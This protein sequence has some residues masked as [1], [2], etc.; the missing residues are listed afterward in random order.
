[1]NQEIKDLI[2]GYDQ[3]E[4]IV[5]IEPLDGQVIIFKEMENGE[6]VQEIRETDYWFLT[7]NL[8]DPKQMELSGNQWYKYM[9]TFPTLEEKEKAR[10]KVIKSGYF[11]DNIYHMY[12]KKE[13]TL[14]RNG[15]TY[16][17]GMK[18]PS[19]I[20]ILSTDIETDGLKQS[21]SSEIY[22]ITN[23]FRRQGVTVQQLFCLADFDDQKSM[24]DA[25]CDWVREI[26]PS[27]II[28]HNF[29]MY[30]LPYLDHVAK[31]NGTSLKLGRDGSEIRFN[32]Y[33]SKKRKD[34]SQD[35]MYKKAYIFGREIVDSLFMSIDYD[36]QRSFES[37]ALKQII[38]DLGLEKKGRS[39]VDAS[40]IKKYFY[41]RENDPVMWSKVE[42]YAI[43][44]TEDPITLFDLMIPAKFFFT[45]SVSKS[46]QEMNTS[47]TG[48]Q[49]NNILVRGYLQN[50]DSV[51]KTSQ[52][53]R[54]VQGGV[55][56]AIPG[57]YKNLYKID[58]KSCYPSQILR[59]QLYDKIKDPK[60]YFYKMVKFFAEQRFELKKQYKATKDEYYKNR[61]G[62]AKIVINSAYGLTI[63]T[64]L[65]YNAIEIGEKITA[66]SRKIID[67]ALIW[68]SG[69]GKDYWMNKFK[70]A[71]GENEEEI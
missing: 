48:S 41:N 9:A 37:Y 7:H 65:N 54:H 11:K 44:D 23:T 26:D 10:M 49:I 52:I 50:G 45:Q 55:S 70:I 63:T 8:L 57:I 38:K 43:E 42:K 18:S 6:I 19:E 67:E 30:D 56:F 24:I 15:M 20:S 16:F 69:K 12:D 3:T 21:D 39:Y 62:A 4:R 5:S 40:Q 61:D 2:F 25:W 66:E 59:F 14:V 47:A 58:I 68:A 29:Y 28:G 71:I 27:I 13:A 51:A 17:K 22:L 64:G 31:L 46:F 36:V 34:G 1:M 32:S 33:E 35:Y 60:A 53:D